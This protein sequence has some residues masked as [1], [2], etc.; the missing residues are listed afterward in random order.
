[1][2]SADGE[3][4]IS[5]RSGCRTSFRGE[6]W[7]T[8]GRSDRH[9]AASGLKAA[10]KSQVEAKLIEIETYATV[11]ISNKH[12]DGLKTQVGVLT[13]KAKRPSAFGVS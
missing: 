10:I 11:Q 5:T 3:S 8:V 1:V 13:I 2:T 4:E 7:G 12:C 9:P 6:H